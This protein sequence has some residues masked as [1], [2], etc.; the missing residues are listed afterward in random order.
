VTKFSQATVCINFELKVQVV[1]SWS[2]R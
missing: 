1:I 2:W